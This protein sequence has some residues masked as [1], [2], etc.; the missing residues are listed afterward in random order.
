VSFVRG[1][2]TL[3]SANSVNVNP[4]TAEALCSPHD[5]KEFLQYR[6]PTDNAI[7]AFIVFDDRSMRVS[8]SLKPVS[9]LEIVIEIRLEFN[10]S[11]ERKPVSSLVNFA[12]IGQNPISIS[13]RIQA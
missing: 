5:V 4:K 7:L 11:E 10:Q 1:K 2:G 12:L 3:I 8:D 6:F 9:Q 13:S